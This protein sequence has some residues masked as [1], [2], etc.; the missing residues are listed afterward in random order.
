VFNVEREGISFSSYLLH[1]KVS[2]SNGWKQ[3]TIREEP[4]GWLSNW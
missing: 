4:K 3:K 2:V 1:T